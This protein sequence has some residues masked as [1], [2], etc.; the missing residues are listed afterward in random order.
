MILNRQRIAFFTVAVAVSVAQGIDKSVMSD[1][2]WAI[3]NDAEQ[4]RIDADIEKN[5]KADASVEIAAP[6]GTVAFRGFRGR[7]RLS[8]TGADGKTATKL[9]EVK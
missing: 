9:V 3:W 7:Y 5:R 6:S 2:Y 4:A 1:K 8:W